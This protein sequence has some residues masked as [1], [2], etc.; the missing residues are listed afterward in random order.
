M[1]PVASSS[2]VTPA[3][4]P[5]NLALPDAPSSLVRD[6]ADAVRQ[7]YRNSIRW[8]KLR[9]RSVAPLATKVGEAMIVPYNK[10]FEDS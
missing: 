8:K 2:E 6:A 5:V 7:E 3:R 1:T 9:C 4:F 10:D